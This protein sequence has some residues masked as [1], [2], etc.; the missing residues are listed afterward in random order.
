MIG[1]GSGKIGNETALISK[2][3]RYISTHYKLPIYVM[4]LPITKKEDLIKLK[5][6][7]VTEIAFNLEICE[8]NIAKL[9]MPGKGRISFSTYIEALQ[10]AVQVFGATGQVRSALL[11]GLD[12]EDDLYATIRLLCG[13]GVAP[14]LSYLRPIENGI[15]KYYV[16]PTADETK[17]IYQKSEEICQSYNLSLGPSCKI[18]Q[19]NTLQL[20]L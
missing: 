5:T 8:R 15:F 3:S 2:I 10:R 20:S 19:N 13:I 1:G 12:K 14:I 17:L 18:C 6:S 4:C 9:I 11:V 16:G 7:G